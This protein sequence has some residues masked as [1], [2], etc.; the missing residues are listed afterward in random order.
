MN[1]EIKIGLNKNLDMINEVLVKVLVI[2]IKEL[3]VLANLDM[4]LDMVVQ[5]EIKVLE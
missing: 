4:N 1:L 2:R 5:I 3:M